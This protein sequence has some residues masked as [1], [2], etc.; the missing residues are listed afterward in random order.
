MKRNLVVIPAKV[1]RK[2]IKAWI[3]AFAGMTFLGTAAAYDSVQFEKAVPLVDKKMNISVLRLDA[4]KQLWVLNPDRQTIQRISREGKTTVV[5]KPGK[6]KDSLFKTPVDFCFL[7]NG[8]MAV[9]DAGLGRI[10]VIGL[11][12]LKLTTQFPVKDPSTLAVS[13]DDILAVGQEGMISLYSIDGVLLHQLFPPEKEAFKTAASLAFGNNGLLW[14]LDGEKGRLHR[15]SSDRTWLGATAGLDNGQSVAVDEFGYAYVTTGKGRWKEINS[16]GEVTG[17]FG[18]KGKEPGAML[19]PS[20]LALAEESLLWVADAGN[21]RLQLFGITNG[22]KKTKL[23]PQPSTYIQVRR[24]SSWPV[25]AEEAL[26]LSRDGRVVLRNSG[27]A[28][29]E[30]RD[31][32]GEVKSSL[33]KTKERAI[34]APAGM[35]VDKEG[36]LW[37]TDQGDHAIK[38]V[39]EPGEVSHKLGEKG[40]KEGSLKG[41]HFL[42]VRNDGSF[43]VVDKGDSRI[44]VLS[45]KGL[46]LFTVGGKGKTKGQFQTISGL[47]ANA[48]RIAVIDDERKALLFYDAKGK[49]LFEITNQEDKTPTWQRL[50]GLAA[51]ADGRF[52]VLDG[53]LRRVRIF[54][55]KGQFIGDF[56]AEGKTLSWGP[57][58]HV[59]LLADKQAAV[60]GVHFVPKAVSNLTA[61]DEEG[62]IKIDW[63]LNPDAATYRIYRSS[64]PHSF[65]LLASTASSPVVDSNVIPGTP[66]TYTV[67]GANDMGY[68]GDPAAAP[69]VKPSRRKDVSL[70]SIAGISF[71]PVFTAAFKSYVGKPFGSVQLTNNDSRPYRNLKLSLSLKRYTDFPTEIA[72]KSIGAG[73]TIGVPVTITFNNQVMELTENTPVQADV[74]LTYFED[75]MEKSVSQNGPILLYSRNAISWNDKAR[76]SSFITPND[77]PIAEFAHD[78]IRDFLVALKG[79][80]VGKPLA[81]AAFFSEALS[82]LEFSYVPDPKTPYAEVSG[83]PQMIDYVQFPR[84]TLRR[85]TG[86]CDDTT[87]LLASLLGSVG[88]EVAL[89]DTPGHIFLMANLEEND[90][91]VIGLPEERF[92]EYKGSY[93]V[94]IETTRLNKGFMDAWQAA[95]S[96]VNTAVEK[97]Q[98]EFVPVLEAVEKYPPVTL[99]E[100]DKTQP[101]AFPTE[102]VKGTFLPLLQ[103]LQAERYKA[104]LARMNAMISKSPEDKGL[105]L[106]LGMAHVEGGNAA[107]GRKI[108]TSLI[109]DPS[110]EVKAGAL[111]NLG[112]L[113]YLEAKYDEAAKHYTEAAK[114]APGDGGIAINRAR[115]AWKM[116]DEKAAKKLLADAKGLTPAWREYTT[117]I[118]AE[119]LPK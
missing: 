16:Q 42:S 60:Y 65:A 104:A 46:F 1:L 71:D 40:K 80:T 85:R 36:N 61:T 62:E 28:L 2:L 11:P 43:V 89:V 110:V 29:L 5:L 100:V 107:E 44:Q 117:E 113:A 114:A 101:S 119:L 92:V 106:R 7:K 77:P 90:A 22:D 15:F 23:F 69:P 10:T 74:R 25:Q 75:N 67:T 73:E 56:S 27:K 20:G 68:E 37:I 49:F 48:E 82:E 103:K 108:F 78:G 93:W 58:T 38:K 19:E 14:I 51:D 98:V 13:H 83:N 76:I 118:P 116:G 3:P 102:K 39:T 99:L 52:Y 24:L 59:L 97:G 86:D 18:A 109:S 8:S 47:A 53:P 105:Q 30:W 63:D 17:T 54:D 96:V 88:V 35:A 33:A 4:Q 6:K 34:L 26:I 66:Y 12:D 84:E 55:P 45:S 81:K 41:P 72:V 111:N 32:S 115:T 87:A 31:S 50:S 64:D 91:E 9:A 57:D 70:V 94:P 95:S 21:K 112:N 79:A